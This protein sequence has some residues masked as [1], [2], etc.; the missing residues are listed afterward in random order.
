METESDLKKIDGRSN[1]AKHIYFYRSCGAEAGPPGH[2]TSA[3]L[4]VAAAPVP[5][6][7]C[8]MVGATTPTHMIAPGSPRPIET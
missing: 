4:P 1:L 3:G 7:C 8:E 6:A 5:L 2:L